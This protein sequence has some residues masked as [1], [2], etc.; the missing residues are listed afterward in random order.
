MVLD[1]RFGNIEYLSDFLVGLPLANAIQYL[2]LAACERLWPEG[3]LH[4]ALGDAAK[5]LRGDSGRAYEFLVSDALDRLHEIVNGRFGRDVTGGPRFGAFDNICCNLL[6]CECQHLRLRSFGA[7]RTNELEALSRPD[8]HDDDA[9]P[10]ARDLFASIR[11][12]GGRA[13]YGH[14]RTRRDA[15]GQTFAIKPNVG[16]DE[17]ARPWRTYGRI[18]CRHLPKPNERKV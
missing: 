12:A 17:D 8:V 10:K 3:R 4:A 18:A 1:G 5:K 2:P 11:S 15:S 6:N 16:D 13:D 7:Q 9:W 14:P